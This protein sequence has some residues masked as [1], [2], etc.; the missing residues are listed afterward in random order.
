MFL[1]RWTSMSHSPCYNVSRRT[2]STTSCWIRLLNVRALWSRCAM[3]QLLQSL[4]T[5]PL[6]IAQE[7]PS[8]LCWEKLLSSIV[9]KT[10][11]T[12]HS[13]N[14]YEERYWLS[15]KLE[16]ASKSHLI[17][18]LPCPPARW[19]TTHLLQPTMPS[20]KKVGP[21]DKKSLS[22]ASLEE[23]I[24]LSCHWVSVSQPKH[25]PRYKS[26]II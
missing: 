13:V 24:S 9:W 18:S 23:N 6:S 12:A 5:P 7:N 20:L 2:W 3:W 1:I 4:P 26:R 21:S 8:T 22:P 11:A 14:R 25:N 19:A 16:P 15:C 17:S 10:A